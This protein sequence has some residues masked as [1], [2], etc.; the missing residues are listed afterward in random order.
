M[1]DSLFLFAAPSFVEGMAR[2]VD[3][4]DTLT[5]A[6]I[7]ANGDEADHAASWADWELITKDLRDAARILNRDVRRVALQE[8]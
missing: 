5:E 4:G 2:I 3:F 7:S 1:S 8:N 6:N